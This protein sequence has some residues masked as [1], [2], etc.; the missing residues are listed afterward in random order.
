MLLLMERHAAFPAFGSRRSGA[1]KGSGLKSRQESCS[2]PGAHRAPG[3]A[4]PHV[5]FPL[6]QENSPWGPAAR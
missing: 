2:S 4:A 1:R 5:P 6:T 3:T